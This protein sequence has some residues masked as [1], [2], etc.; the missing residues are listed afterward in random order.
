MS[1]EHGERYQCGYCGECYVCKHR[2][3]WLSQ[4]GKWM[5]RNWRGK[6]EPLP[7]QLEPGRVIPDDN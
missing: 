7:Y 5:W 6:L 2:A 4:D 1:C 3:V